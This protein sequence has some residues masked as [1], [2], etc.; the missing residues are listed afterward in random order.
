MGVGIR[1]GLLVGVW[2]GVGKCGHV[3][4]RVIK[5][6]QIWKGQTDRKGVG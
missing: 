6:K 1:A 3:W 4:A 5:I 2:M